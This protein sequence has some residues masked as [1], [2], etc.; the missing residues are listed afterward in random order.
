MSDHWV[1][2]LQRNAQSAAK[3]RGSNGRKS[4]AAYDLTDALLEALWEKQKGRCFWTAA[5]LETATGYARS[6][7]LDRLD[8]AQ[9]Y[10]E[11]NLVLCCRWVNYARNVFDV[12]ATKSLICQIASDLSGVAKYAADHP[13]VLV[14]KYGYAGQ[15]W[16]K[17]STKTTTSAYKPVLG[18]EPR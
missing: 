15:P 7:S 12:E 18:E 14:P 2:R 16:A 11:G 1:K 10:V 9:G 4:A 5:P 17:R 8:P 6:V 3:L 13:E